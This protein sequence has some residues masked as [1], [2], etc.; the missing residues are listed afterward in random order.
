[1]SDD[2]IEEIRARHDA[3]PR[4]QIPLMAYAVAHADRAD[5]LAEVERLRE[6]LRWYADQRNHFPVEHRRRGDPDP[7]V[8]FVDEP[9]IVTDCGRRAREALE[10]NP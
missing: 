4:G 6:A 9:A 10:G 7:G 2:K 5:L 1:M 8:V 3:G